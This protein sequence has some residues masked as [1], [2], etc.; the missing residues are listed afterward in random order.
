MM[1]KFYGY[2]ISYAQ[3]LSEDMDREG[4]EFIC[5]IFK[6]LLERLPKNFNM[7]EFST[8]PIDD[9][10]RKRFIDTLSSLIHETLAL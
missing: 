6:D 2:K 4:F 5:R 3:S 10:E 7:A 8:Q 1:Y 9:P